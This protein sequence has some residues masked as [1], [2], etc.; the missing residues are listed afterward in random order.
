VPAGTIACV[1]RPDGHPPEVLDLD[2]I[3]DEATLSMI[4]RRDRGVA[5]RPPTGT[6]GAEPGHAGTGGGAGPAGAEAA[7]AAEAVRPVRFRGVRGAVVAGAMLGVAEVF[8]P[9]PDK[10]SVI[11][12]APAPADHHD[13]PIEFVYVHGS[14]QHSRIIFRPWL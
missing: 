1:T 3:Y 9:E 10:Q 14:P 5:A 7:E 2:E 6:T 12:F 8:E 4:D 13:D 11:E